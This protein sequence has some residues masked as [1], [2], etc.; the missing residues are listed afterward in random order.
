MP[1]QHILHAKHAL[2]VQHHLKVLTHVH[3]A[4]QVSMQLQVLLNVRTALQTPTLRLVLL[5]V[6]IAQQELILLKAPLHVILSA[7]A[8]HSV[9]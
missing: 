4:Q 9:Q 8:E 3:N 1:T 6:P 5:L 2:L 7:R